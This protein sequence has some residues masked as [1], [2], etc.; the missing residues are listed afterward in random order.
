MVEE[1]GAPERKRRE[2]ERER[3][4]EQGA[5]MMKIYAKREAEFFKYCFVLMQLS[6]QSL[7]LY[8]HLVN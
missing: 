4:R 7:M 3:E 8:E 6:V 2:R 5:L 1:R